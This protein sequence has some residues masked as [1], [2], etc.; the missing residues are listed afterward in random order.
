MPPPSSSQSPSRASSPS[1]G[2]TVLGRRPREEEPGETDIPFGKRGHTDPLIHH[3]RHFGRTMHSFCRIYTLISDGLIRN[4]AIATGRLELR[5]LHNELITALR[6]RREHELFSQLMAHVPGLEERL[7]S[8]AGEYLAYVSSM[9]TKGVSTARSDDTKGIKHA[10]LDW[11]TPPGAYLVPPLSR[12][13]KSDCGF[14]HP[15]TGKFLCP[16]EYNWEDAQ[17]K[18]GLRGGTL[19]VTGDS[20]PIF[21]YENYVYYPKEPLKGL[22]RSDIMLSAYKFVFTS[23]SSAN[24]QTGTRATRSGN[25][26]IH[27]MTR[28]TPPSLAYIAMQVRF[29]LS[30]T[31]TFSRNGLQD[32]NQRFYENLL[33]TFDSLMSPKMLEDLLQ[34]WDQ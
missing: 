15:T 18:E 6:E 23:P 13:V 28:V 21:M 10:I 1:E 31:S 5:S 11:I 20:W 3:G 12:N 24:S 32:D 25:A 26:V 22:L 17:V 33:E 7:Y 8:S 9:V 30:S 27:G 29:A 14:F 16:A 34:W 19:A 4:D 2:T